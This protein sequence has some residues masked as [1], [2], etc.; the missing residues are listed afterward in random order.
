MGRDTGCVIGG[1][2]KL[3]ATRIAA[4]LVPATQFPQAVLSPREIKAMTLELFEAE[5]EF[6]PGYK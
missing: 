1:R 6:L 4:C 5:K 3:A 2:P